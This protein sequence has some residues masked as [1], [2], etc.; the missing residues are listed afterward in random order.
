MVANLNW[1]KFFLLTTFVTSIAIA[2]QPKA[3]SC[4]YDEAGA[5]E[6]TCKGYVKLNNES[7]DTVT[8]AFQIA[9]SRMWKAAL[10]FCEKENKA[11]E[12]RNYRKETPIYTKNEVSILGGFRCASVSG[13]K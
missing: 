7:I 4:K 11:Y 5:S 2:E 13:I 1:S 12:L 10:R 9:E 8:D 3:N 6:I